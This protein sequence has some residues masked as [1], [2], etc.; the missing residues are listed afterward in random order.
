MD[1]E[2][3]KQAKVEAVKRIYET[4]RVGEEAKQEIIRLHSQA[5]GYVSQLGLAPEAET[6]L[7][8][9]AAALL[10]RQK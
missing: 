6:L 9:Y 3:D 8:S 10:G 5:L 4:L 1:S 7:R 2:A